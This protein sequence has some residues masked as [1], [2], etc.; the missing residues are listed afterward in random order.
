MKK[1]KLPIYSFYI[2][3]LLCLSACS[4]TIN[5]IVDDL[6]K[7]IGQVNTEARGMSSSERLLA[8]PE[9]PQIEVVED[10]GM[11]YDFTDENK[12][13]Y[14]NLVSQS[15]IKSKAGKCVLASNSATVDMSLAFDTKLGP[16]ARQRKTDKP[17]LTFP[18]FVAVTGLDG[19][20]M[21]KEVFAASM[22]FDTG[23]NH[24]V[25]H[26][27]LRQIIPIK[28]KDR[29]YR[30]RILV[31]FQ[32][33]PEQLAYN[34]SILKPK[35]VPIPKRK[36]KI[37]FVDGEIKDSSSADYGIKSWIKSPFGMGN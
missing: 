26:E 8:E 16:K 34:R 2:V 3:C 37:E 23:E 22:S 32:L 17:F 21:A 15:K 27:Y 36:P 20:I 6:N 4:E 1:I 31:G 35:G 19:K 11:I 13:L 5:G 7:G 24:R 12:N 28:Y 14:E 33:T 10:L 25:H 30:Y 29:A 9:C 18:F